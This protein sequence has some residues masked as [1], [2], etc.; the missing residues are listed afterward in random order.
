MPRL[1]T[2]ARNVYP[3][4]L[5]RAVFKSATAPCFARIRVIKCTADGTATFI[6]P[7]CLHK[8]QK[9]IWAVASCMA[10]RSGLYLHTILPRTKMEGSRMDG[11]NGDGWKAVLTLYAG[12]RK[13]RT[14][15]YLRNYY[16]IRGLMVYCNL[17]FFQLVF[18]LHFVLLTF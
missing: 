8:L 9:S 2:E 16:K 18:L 7:T 13:A 11:W 14:G 4:F 17:L 5:S 15:L 10:T 6:S 3:L 1:E 12:R